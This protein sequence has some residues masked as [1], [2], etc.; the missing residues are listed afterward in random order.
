MDGLDMCLVDISLGQDYS[1]EY[2]II[3]S[4]YEKFDSFTV[5]L[6]NKTIN[7]I[8]YLEDLNN[9]IGKLFSNIVDKYYSIEYIDAISMHGQTVRHLEKIESIQAGNP[10]F[11]YEKFNVPIIHN[12]RHADILEGGNGAPLMPFLDWLL[13]RKYNNDV[14]TLNIGGISNIS[15][16]KNNCDLNNVVGFDTGPGMSLID[17]FTLLNWGIRYDKDGILARKGKINNDL[18]DYLMKNKYINKIPPKSTGRDIFGLKFVND[19]MNKFQNINRFDMLRTLVRFT[20]ASIIFNLQYLQKIVINNST[21]IISGG[22]INNKL[23][24]SDINEIANFKNIIISDKVGINPDYKESLLMAVLG[25]GKILKLNT[26][27]PSVTG[28][29]R[30]V[31]CGEIYG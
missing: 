2:H 22:G 19:I 3:D 6:I 15:F 29:K 12:F 9:H 24:F 11:L 25:L 20:A 27:V 23:L 7:N 8:K 1:F 14:V 31:S 28:A 17:E 4:N 26:N 30:F 10:K 16:I 13:F 21:L 5:E 18:L